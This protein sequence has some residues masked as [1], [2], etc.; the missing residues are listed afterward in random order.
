MRVSCSV[1]E[2]EAE[3]S[4]RLC[5]RSVA[6]VPAYNDDSLGAVFVSPTNTHVMTIH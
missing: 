1:R 2:R 6:E 3:V 4:E 5:M